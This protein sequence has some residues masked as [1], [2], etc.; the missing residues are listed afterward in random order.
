MYLAN[1]LHLPHMY[2]VNTVD[3]KQQLIADVGHF[4]IFGVFWSKNKSEKSK[5]LILS[6]KMKSKSKLKSD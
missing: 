6:P 1:T 2:L 5:I 3:N 4:D